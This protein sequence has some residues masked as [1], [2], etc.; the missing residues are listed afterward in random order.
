[1]QV[2]EAEDDV[3]VTVDE[4]ETE[5]DWDVDEIELDEDDVVLIEELDDG[6]EL[7]ELCVVD[8]LEEE[9]P[10]IGRVLAKRTKSLVVP[11]IVVLVP[12]KHQQ[13]P[14]VELSSWNATVPAA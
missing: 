9:A 2:E 5:L 4:D 6:R 13:L 8:E 12:V 1:V 3:E 10:H 11:A 14:E 7:V